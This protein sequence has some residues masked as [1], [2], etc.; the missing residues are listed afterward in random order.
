MVIV[1]DCV[2]AWELLLF[3]TIFF[4][5][6]RAACSAKDAAWPFTQHQAAFP[7]ILLSISWRIQHTADAILS[8]MRSGRFRI[9]AAF[10]SQ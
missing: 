7:L 2:Y 10:V 5:F 9:T 3:I 6:G 1:G 4:Q 8:S